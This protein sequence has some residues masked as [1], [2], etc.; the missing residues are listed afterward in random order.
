MVKG[1]PLEI[2]MLPVNMDAVVTASVPPFTTAAEFVLAVFSD[3][4]PALLVIGPVKV[5]APVNV[6]VPEPFLVK[7]PVPFATN[8]IV[9]T[10][11]GTGLAP[12]PIKVR[13]KFAAS[14]AR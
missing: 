5:F 9:P 13:V 8:V 6:R 3:R 12:P 4:T 1:A 7:P 10:V 14:P 11:G 2:V